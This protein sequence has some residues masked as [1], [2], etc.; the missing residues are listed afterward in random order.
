MAS[1]P[2][3]LAWRIPR[4]QSIRTQLKWLSTHTAHM[5]TSYKIR[6]P[7]C[8]TWKRDK[9]FWKENSFHPLRSV[10]DFQQAFQNRKRVVVE[11]LLTCR[12]ELIHL[13]GKWLLTEGSHNHQTVSGARGMGLDWGSRKMLDLS[14]LFLFLFWPRGVWDLNS[15]TRDR[16]CVSCNRSMES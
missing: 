8:P 7:A 15:P 6:L 2:S 14:F 12:D 9:R 3:I 11:W 13:V 1:H 16:T 10:E 5:L 4:L